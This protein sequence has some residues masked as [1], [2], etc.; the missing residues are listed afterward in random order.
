MQLLVN[1][2]NNSYSLEIYNL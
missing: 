2:W 1:F